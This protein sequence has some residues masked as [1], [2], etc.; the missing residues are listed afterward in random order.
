MSLLVDGSVPAEAFK[1]ETHMWVG[2]EVIND[3]EDDGLLSFELGANRVVKIAPSYD[4]KEAIL[5][6]KSTYLMGT[7][8]PDAV[9]DMV[10]GQMIVHPGGITNGSKDDGSVWYSSQWLEY[11]LK[12]GEK[13]MKPKAFAYGY[14]THASTDVFSHT[15]INQYSGEV[16]SFFE[17]TVVSEY[18]HIKLEQFIADR[19]PPLRD[20][21]GTLLGDFGDQLLLDKEYGEYIRDTLIYPDAIQ[22]QYT[23][24]GGEHLAAITK[25]KNG[26]DDLANQPVWAEI[27]QEIL[28][29]ISNYYG[30]AIT[31][32]QTTVILELLQKIIN[33]SNANIDQQQK[34][35]DKL[36]TLLANIDNQRFGDLAKATTEMQGFETKAL[37]KLQ[38]WRN[39]LDELKPNPP[40]CPKI[41]GYKDEC[42]EDWLGNKICGPVPTMVDDPVCNAARDAVINF[43]DTILSEATKLENRALHYKYDFLSRAED[44]RQEAQKVGDALVLINK[45]LIDLAEVLN[46]NVSPIKGLLLSWNNDIDEAMSAYGVA[47]SETLVNTMRKETLL[48]E[49]FE[50]WSSCADGELSGVAIEDVAQVM[51]DRGCEVK[52]TIADFMNDNNVSMY[53]AV[54][55]E[56]FYEP[57]KEWYECY[58]NQLLGVPSELSGC[59]LRDSLGEIK[60]SIRNILDLLEPMAVI[61]EELGAP[62]RKELEALQ[63][64]ILDSVQNKIE[65]EALTYVEEQMGVYFDE[66]FLSK[67]LS[68]DQLQGV[69]NATYAGAP[70]GLLPIPN[71]AQRVRLEMGIT[72]V[73]ASDAYF[74]PKKYT[75]VYNAVVLS[76][77]SLL[78]VEGIRELI[79]QAGLNSSDYPIEVDNVVASFIG[80]LDGHHQWEKTKVPQLPA[81]D[82]SNCQ[83][84]KTTPFRDQKVFVLFDYEDVKEEVFKKLFAGAIS[85][86]LAQPKK[87][88]KEALRALNKKAFINFKRQTTKKWQNAKKLWK[89]EMARSAKL[90]KKLKKRKDASWKDARASWKLQKEQGRQEWIELKTFNTIEYQEAKKIRQ[91]NRKA[92]KD[93]EEMNFSKECRDAYFPSLTWRKL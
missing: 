59:E 79:D 72:D 37:S 56:K 48:V 44:V 81:L 52:E 55:R 51:R 20:V 71:I 18:R 16:F 32:E 8:G 75:V 28:K 9:P 77:L 19:T 54:E 10:A 91:A 12:K 85:Q 46:S 14:L 2:Q 60:E 21:Q 4:V 64:T 89:K 13:G 22:K 68:D 26:V 74:N 69:F 7:I 1:L 3:L 86:G 53:K 33:N 30:Y 57:A 67:G 61:G 78:D 39:K 80:S 11:L 47:M 42:I 58:E 5:N 38:E 41:P 35:T 65:K 87:L 23:A 62:S 73:N 82:R 34:Y 31:T 27:D 63:A 40:A 70:T 66:I 43:N 76:K 84:Y 49:D 90:W 29:M 92:V 24:L 45:L 83:V 93:V 36:Y 6:N 88:K 25:L 50:E 17:D 15:Y